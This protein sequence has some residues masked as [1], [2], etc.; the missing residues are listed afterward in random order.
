MSRDC[1]QQRLAD[2]FGGKLHIGYWELRERLVKF[3]VGPMFLGA[4]SQSE[5][6]YFVFV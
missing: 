4:S 5:P 1:S 2:H 6:V 3:R